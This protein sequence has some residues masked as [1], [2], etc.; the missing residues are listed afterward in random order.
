[1]ENEGPE[2][3]PLGRTIV[4]LTATG[5]YTQATAMPGPETAAAAA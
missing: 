2:S 3:D 4:P 1:M 5:Q